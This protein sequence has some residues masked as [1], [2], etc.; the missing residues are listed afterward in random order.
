MNNEV[1]ITAIY[2]DQALDTWSDIVASF[3]YERFAYNSIPTGG[4][5][6]AFFDNVV[7]LPRNGGPGYSLGYAPNYQKDYCKQNAYSGLQAAFLAIGFDNKGLFAVAADGRNGIPLSAANNTHTATVRGGVSEN[8]EVFDTINLTTSLSTYSNSST[9]TVDQSAIKGQSIPNRAVRVLLQNHA[10]KLIVQ[11]KD[12]S[13][14]EEFDTIYEKALPER[15]RRALKVGLLNTRNDEATKFNVIS[16]NVAGFPGIGTTQKIEGCKSVVAQD[17]YGLVDSELCVG[18]EYIVTGLPNK[19]VTYTT[20]TVKYNFKNSIFTGSGIRITGNSQNYVVGTY[21]NKPTVGIFRYLGEKLAKSVFIT[22][23]NNEPAKWADIDMN[24]GTLAIL[25]R[26]VSGTLYLYNFIN[27][28]EI[29][30]ILGTWQLYQTINY[31]SRLHKDFA[32]LDKVKIHNDHL[33]VNAA[34]EKVHAYRKNIFNVWEYVQTLSATIRPEFITGFGEEFAIDGNDLLIGAPQS[35]KQQHPEPTQGEVY[36]YVFSSTQKKWNLAMALGSFYG[37]NTP[38]GTFGASIAFKNNICAIGSPGEE[39]RFS[40]SISDVNIGRIHVFRK[41]PSGLFSQGTAIAPEGKYR[42]RNALFGTK[43]SLYENY[44]Y[45]LSPYKENYPYSYITVLDLNC[46]FELPPPQLPIPACALIT[47]DNRS[48]IL[49]FI[50]DT[51]MLSY[52]CREGVTP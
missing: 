50:T 24:T 41:T 32:L 13:E 10:T 5:A 30:D 48:F 2:N 43:V 45:A 20:D 28:S 7:N 14:K 34:Y 3:E 22:I 39:Y 49:D 40:D 33:I 19:V 51:Y 9:F 31:D 27:N 8:Y 18:S 36:H 46:T 37:L 1:D 6:L 16:F 21:D 25:T 52:S 42:E 38:L 12:S 15:D 11:L 23:P 44:L 47:F 26:S 35:Q 17:T 4:F 29:S